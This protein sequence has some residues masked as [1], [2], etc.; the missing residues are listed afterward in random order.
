MAIG[1]KRKPKNHQVERC[2]P[3]LPMQVGVRISGNTFMPG[4]EST[5]TENVSSRGARVRSV[6]RWR[7]GESICVLSPQA[8]FR[9]LARVAYCE[10]SAAGYSIGIE[11]LELEG[12]WVLASAST[13][14]SVA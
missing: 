6:R 8:G 1:G 13:S 9:S 10:S 7:I 14:G 2:E 3:R 12:Q 5:F 11:F 4:M